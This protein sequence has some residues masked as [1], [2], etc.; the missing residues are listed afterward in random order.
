MFVSQSKPASSFSAVEG[1]AAQSGCSTRGI[2][3]GE[4]Q[5]ANGARLSILTLN[6]INVAL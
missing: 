4:Y 6:S 2:G 1:G 5:S 3:R